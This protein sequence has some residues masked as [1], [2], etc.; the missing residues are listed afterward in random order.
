[1]DVFLPECQY[2]HPGP[3]FAARMKQWWKAL[4]VPEDTMTVLLEIAKFL[5]TAALTIVTALI[6]LMSG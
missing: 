1:V 4:A 2:L 3:K 6:L 5:A